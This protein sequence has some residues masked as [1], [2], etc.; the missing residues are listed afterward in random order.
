MNRVTL[1]PGRALIG[2]ITAWRRYVSPLYG[3][4]CRYHPSCSAYALEAVSRHGALRGT[5]LASWRLLRCNPLSDGGYDPVPELVGRASRRH[6]HEVSRGSAPVAAVT[7]AGM[8]DDG[9]DGRSPDGSSRSHRPSDSTLATV[10]LS[11][12]TPSAVPVTA[13]AG[14]AR[15]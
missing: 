12:M 7:A 8:S 10:P 3:P 14:D 1:L 2:A 6:R 5:G 4:R 15:P 9:G 13:V 11:P